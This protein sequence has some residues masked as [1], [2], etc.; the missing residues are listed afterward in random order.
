VFSRRALEA[1]TTF[2]DLRKILGGD[3]TRYVTLNTC[4]LD[5]IGTVEIR[6]HSGTLEAG[7]ILLWTSLWQQILWAASQDREPPEVHDA[8]VITPSG[9]I[10][11]LAREWLPPASQTEQRAFLERLARRRREVVSQWRKKP[12]LEP[13]LAAT[14]SWSGID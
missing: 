11:A 12:D 6:M 14:K 10:L 4:S 13:W 5:Q 9:D 7:K 3:D 8:K 1:V 2:D